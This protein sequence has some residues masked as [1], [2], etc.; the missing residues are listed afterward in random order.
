MG[1][2]QVDFQEQ[3][4]IHTFNRYAY[5]AN[6]P[7]RY[8]DPDGKCYSTGSIDTYVGPDLADCYV[9]EGSEL[10]SIATGIYGLGRLGG[11]ILSRVFAREAVTMGDD[12][13]K[14]ATNW[15]NQK[16]LADHFTRHGADVG[17]KSADDYANKASDF[18]KRSQTE[19]LPTKID[20]DGTIRVF[21]PKNNTFGAYNPDG[22]T[23][24]FF[25]P[26]SQGYWD[27]QPGSSP[28]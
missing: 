25:K 7:Y 26:S 11:G 1:V 21:D 28:W 3:N 12:V 2:D 16:T 14:G 13:A 22:T 15:G 19:R 18:F 27:R 8:K 24:T 6:N 20:A 4:P 9:G 23:K 5:A 10:L 17:A